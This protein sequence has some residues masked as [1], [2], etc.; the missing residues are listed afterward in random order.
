MR[1]IFRVSVKTHLTDS[2]FEHVGYAYILGEN[3]G[4][5][6]FFLT[7]VLVS[8][9]VLL[10]VAAVLPSLK[11]SL[12]CNYGNPEGSSRALVMEYILL[13]VAESL[14]GPERDFFRNEKGLS[15]QGRRRKK[16]QLFTTLICLGGEL[17]LSKSGKLLLG[18][19]S[20]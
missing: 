15:N 7:L 19:T 17:Q 1:E 8:S 11:Y 6:F 9:S 5:F 4:M 14:T 12:K 3:R 18:S 2:Y 13:T 20:G 16:R 10:Y